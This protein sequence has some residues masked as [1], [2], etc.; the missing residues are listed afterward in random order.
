MK[1]K[2]REV[3][4]PPTD[5]LEDYNWKGEPFPSE[6]FVGTTY[7]VVMLDSGTVREVAA[8]KVRRVE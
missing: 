2:W 1:V 5:V 4:I 6:D 7:L 8:S 3:Y